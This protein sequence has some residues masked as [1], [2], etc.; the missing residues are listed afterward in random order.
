M[1]LKIIHLEKMPEL[2]IMCDNNEIT[3]FNFK[4]LNNNDNYIKTKLGI[5]KEL[6]IN[7]DK[8]KS[9]TYN[10]RLILEN[11]HEFL[12]FFENNKIL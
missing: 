1:E 8:R 9:L 3:S 6:I 12:N 4:I 10:K 11:P 2:N 5:G 7:E